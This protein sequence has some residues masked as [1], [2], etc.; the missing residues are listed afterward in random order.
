MYYRQ[1]GNIIRK[2][3]PKQNI[4]EEFKEDIHQEN[5][6]E[7][8]MK[9]LNY[10]SESTCGKFPLWALILII[11]ALLVLGICLTIWIWKK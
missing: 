9:D 3:T 6:N 5:T 1:K 7:N 11:I 10:T 2:S 4:K 8:H